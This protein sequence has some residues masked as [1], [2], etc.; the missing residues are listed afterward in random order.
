M[1]RCCCLP[2][3]PARLPP[4]HSVWPVLT[5]SVTCWRW[6]PRV[7]REQ[8]QR[9]GSEAGAAH[10]TGRAFRPLPLC[11]QR[12]QSLKCTSD[13][14]TVPAALAPGPVGCGSGLPGACRPGMQY[15]GVCKP[16]G[17]PSPG[18]G[19]SMCP[20]LQNGAFPGGQGLNHEPTTPWSCEANLRAH[21]RELLAW[22]GTL[23]G[24]SRHRAEPPPPPWAAHAQGPSGASWGG[25]LGLLSSPPRGGGWVIAQSW[26]GRL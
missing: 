26:P 19:R 23:T 4:A 7:A 14:C 13:W 10:Q 21:R 16:I 15:S 1:S 6:F 24:A 11:Q 5:C 9:G 12:G 25:S 17:K 18:H 2:G 20:T 8:P 22:R 3:W